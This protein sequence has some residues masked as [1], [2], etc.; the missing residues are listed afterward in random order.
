MQMSETQNRG[1][2]S[3]VLTV[4]SRQ[5]SVMRW[6]LLSASFNDASAA[7][8]EPVLLPHAMHQVNSTQHCIFVCRCC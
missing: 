6:V 8:R 3:D 4:G 5:A 1:R 7:P 2:A